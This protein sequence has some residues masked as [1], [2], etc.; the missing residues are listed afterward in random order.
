MKKKN[1]I[2]LGLALTLLVSG[3]GSSSSESYSSSYDAAAEEATYGDS[4]YGYDDYNDY[5]DYEE[6]D[7]E[8]P[9]MASSS[10]SDWLS[11][12]KDSSAENGADSGTADAEP[13]EGEDQDAGG[14]D[15]EELEVEDSDVSA[16]S[17]KLNEEKL[18]YR[19]SISIDT[20]D[21]DT[22]LK[23]LKALLKK[24]DGFLESENYSDGN[25]YYSSYYY[26]ESYEK[27]RNYTATFRVPTTNYEAILEEMEGIGDMR[28][29][30][31]NVE[32]LSQE[33]SDLAITLDVLKQTYERYSALM[34]NATD[35]DY[36]LTIQEKLTDT[37]IRI[38]EV[39]SRMNVI[40]RDVA[41]STID[42]TLRE[43]RE[44]SAE[45]EPEDTFVQRLTKTIKE[46]WSTFLS[47]M[48]GLLFLI[49]RLLPFAV[50]I[51]IIA[52]IVIFIIK[53]TGYSK[54]KLAERKK[55]REEAKRQKAEETAK[56]L[57]EYREREAQKKAQASDAA[58][59]DNAKADD[60]T[61]GN[62]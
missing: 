37:Q 5:G 43:V 23:D 61:G 50:F 30:N 4:D 16:S 39:K 46:S 28:S 2:A 58:K 31:A 11:A 60:T 8:E 48:E 25:D 19:C 10:S 55:A 38:E 27:N 6:Y 15:S 40:N 54:E 49:I 57:A 41:Y 26:V 21:Y 44:Y 35:E 36:I 45:P 62:K 29:K 53:K 33:Y 51:L 22:S 3:C 18:V 42:V 34:D 13:V 20:L 14:D 12:R 47:F 17:A 7:A 56:R 59:T 52:L 1:V 24:Y 32:N 9:A